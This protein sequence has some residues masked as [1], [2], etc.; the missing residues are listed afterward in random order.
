MKLSTHPRKAAVAGGISLLFTLV[1]LMVTAGTANAE[2]A[3]AE[4]VLITSPGDSFPVA[5]TRQLAASPQQAAQMRMVL[6]Q[7]DELNQNIPWGASS[8]S[9]EQIDLAN[10]AFDRELASAGA[11]QAYAAQTAPSNVEMEILSTSLT[12]SNSGTDGISASLTTS[13]PSFVGRQQIQAFTCSN[14]NC[15]L[16]STRYLDSR[17]D[18]GLATAIVNGKTS[19]G[20]GWQVTATARCMRGSSSCGSRSIPKESTYGPGVLWRFTSSIHRAKI[21][22]TFS[23]TWFGIPGSVSGSTPSITCTSSSCKFD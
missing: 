5:V 6:D 9:A 14:G 22:T 4:F 21:T 3:P 7:F 12:A 17:F 2:A 11:G 19:G 23:G 8:V 18:L 10:D 20:T 13:S 1:P 16:Q 15:T